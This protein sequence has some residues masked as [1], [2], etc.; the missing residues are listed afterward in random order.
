MQQTWQLLHACNVITN[1][2]RFAL[3]MRVQCLFTCTCAL[4]VD[5]LVI[6]SI[7]TDDC[8]AAWILLHARSMQSGES[9]A[10]IDSLQVKLVVIDSITFHFRQDTQDMAQ[11]TRTLASLAQSLTRLAAYRR[12][13]IVL[14]NQVTTKVS[15]GGQSR[16]IPALGERSPSNDA[17][18]SC[19]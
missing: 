4:Q 16:I 2:G 12:I 9:H 19:G 13:A 11:R 17:H 15:D 10:E 14:M 3:K 8:S 7:T 1:E 18:V 6:D 5:W